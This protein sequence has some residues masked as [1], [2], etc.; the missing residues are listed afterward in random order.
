[1]V[2]SGCEGHLGKIKASRSKKIKEDLHTLPQ[3]EHASPASA[4]RSDQQPQGQRS[5][6]TDLGWFEGIIC[7]EVDGEEED[8]ALVRAVGLQRETHN[9]WLHI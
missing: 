7:G 3:P 1:M 6:V 2:D 5:E 8:A 4:S 9:T